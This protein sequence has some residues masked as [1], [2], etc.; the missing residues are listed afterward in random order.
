MKPTITDVTIKQ[1]AVMQAKNAKRLPSVSD[2]FMIWSIF[3][4]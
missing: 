3:M 2:S 4:F 1:N